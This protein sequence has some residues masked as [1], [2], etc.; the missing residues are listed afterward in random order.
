MLVRTQRKIV[1]RRTFLNLPL[2]GSSLQTHR[3]AKK[4]NVPPRLIFDVVSDLSKYNDFVPFVTQAFITK[5]D[6]NTKLP[7][8]GGFR[9][10]WKQFDELF[11]CKLTC[12]PDKQVVAESIS[13][14]LFESLYSEWNFQEVKSRFS[15]ELST[16][17]ELLLTYKFKNPL[18]NAASSMFQNQVSDIMIN[19]FEKRALEMKV[20]SKLQN[21]G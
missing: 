8:E 13:K 1:F 18:Y 15:K 17:V 7:T 14:Q 2:S 20:R 3:V 12:S 5:S 4:I 9:V 16:H 19:A 21:R 6:E 11:N 10:G